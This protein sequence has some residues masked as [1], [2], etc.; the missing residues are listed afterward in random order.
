MWEIPEEGIYLVDKMKSEYKRISQNFQIESG[1]K[2]HRD[3]NSLE[4]LTNMD[5]LAAISFYAADRGDFSV[6]N[7]K[8]VIVD[9]IPKA[10]SL[11]KQGLGGLILSLQQGAFGKIGGVVF[12]G[13]VGDEEVRT[14]GE[15]QLTVRSFDGRDAV[16]IFSEVESG[17]DGFGTKVTAPKGVYFP[18]IVGNPPDNRI[19]GNKEKNSNGDDAKMNAPG[20]SSN[21]IPTPP[22]R[23][24]QIQMAK[25]LVNK[26]LE[27]GKTNEESVS[28]WR[29]A[30]LIGVTPTKTF[31]YLNYP[32]RNYN[33]IF[34]GSS[35]PE[36]KLDSGAACRVKG[37]WYPMQFMKNPKTK[38]PT[39]T[40]NEWVVGRDW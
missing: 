9:T 16:Y 5:N 29:G 23:S 10:I 15:E 38:I 18:V 8:I 33:V 27:K 17:S 32:C 39:K 7:G 2:M 13:R 14:I 25:D 4:N 36:M 31:K 1:S 30:K 37:N 19:I 34:Y 11:Y 20:S 35:T 22:P 28:N 24:Q 26:T 12:S 21:S 3:P 40:Y 6:D